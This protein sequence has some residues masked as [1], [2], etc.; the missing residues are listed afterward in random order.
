MYRDIENSLLGGVCGGLASYYNVDRTLL[1]LLFVASFFIMGGI[2]LILYLALWLF[3]KANSNNISD[4]SDEKWESGFSKEQ[5][6]KNINTDIEKV[7]N[8]IE[9]IE[10]VCKSSIDEIKKKLKDK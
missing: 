2:T 4:T 8:A 1:R 6:A 10:K 3:L 5:S 9:N 7:N